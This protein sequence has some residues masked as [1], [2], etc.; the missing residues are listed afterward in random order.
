MSESPNQKSVTEHPLVSGPP[1][2]TT[3][4][5]VV[6]SQPP[7]IPNENA[8][9]YCLTRRN[10]F[11]TIIAILLAIGI[12]YIVISWRR[13][14]LYTGLG[15]TI[16]TGLGFN[17]APRGFGTGSTVAGMGQQIRGGFK[18]LFKGFSFY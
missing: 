2:P 10:I 18:K 12:I 16:G 7:L 14:I 13:A 17:S 11:D 8:T 9:A 15:Q 3:K 4:T 5:I 6:T 1:L